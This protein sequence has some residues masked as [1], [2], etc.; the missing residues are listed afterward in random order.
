MTGPGGSAHNPIEKV[1]GFSETRSTFSIQLKL[2][3][4]WDYDLVITG[5]GFRR[6]AI[7][8][9]RDAVKFRTKK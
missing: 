2:K 8:Y 1:T 3:P 7:R 4:D 6:M 5:R 9:S